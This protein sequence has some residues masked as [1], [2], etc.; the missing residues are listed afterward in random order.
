MT[1][2][3]AAR[4]STT[5]GPLTAQPFSQSPQATRTSSGWG[6]EVDGSSPWGSSTRA[7]STL[8]T[9]SVLSGNGVVIPP[10]YERVWQAADPNAGV[11]SIGALGKVLGAGGIKASA[12][13]KIIGLV[14]KDGSFVITRDAFMVALA[15]LAFAQ[16]FRP[17]SVEDVHAARDSLPIPT[18]P[19]SFSTPPPPPTPPVRAPSEASIDPWSSA[20]RHNSNSNGNGNGPPPATTMSSSPPSYGTLSQM[21]GSIFEED[22]MANPFGANLPAAGGLGYGD[23]EEWA[24]GRQDKV[25]VVQREELGGWIFQHTLWYVRCE[26]TSSNVER[27][28]SDFTWLLESLTRRYPFRLLPVLPPK[29][30]QVSGVY[31]GVDD[32]FLERRKKGLERFLAFL[33]NHPIFRVDGLVHTFLTEQ[34][35]LSLWRKHTPFSLDEES[36]SRTLSPTDEMTIPSDLDSKLSQLRSRILPLVEHWTR[37]SQTLERVVHRRQ[38]QGGDLAKLKIALDAARETEGSGWRPVEVQ[39]VEQAMEAFGEGVGRAG[40]I[41]SVSALRAMDSIVEEVKRHRELYVQLR[42]LFS[43]QHSLSPDAVER[44]KKRVTSNM[45]K[46]DSLRSTPEPSKPTQHAEDLDRLASSIEKDQRHIDL[47]LRRRV[48]IRFCMWQ[49][50]VLLFR[51]TSLLSRAFQEYVG[52]EIAFDGRLQANWDLLASSLGN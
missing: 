18:L 5:T 30:L 48:F 35:D 4:S 23:G 17:L 9:A 22:E 20:S 10:L 16:A 24:L 34:S 27:R 46:L 44:L 37:I 1:S 29:R 52:D 21:H 41:E 39:M 50:I 32:M 49:E 13:E 6:G 8:S 12:V 26:K 11:V 40:E 28:Y 51:G 2:F 15:L 31:I 33:I 25:E 47:L 43:R 19:S 38:Q 36:V 7:A 14:S 42:D 45:S 3:D